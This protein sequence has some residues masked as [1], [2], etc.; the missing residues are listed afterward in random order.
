MICLNEF[1]C[2]EHKPISTYDDVSVVVIDRHG[3]CLGISV[4][5]DDGLVTFYVHDNCMFLKHVGND[6][7]LSTLCID[8]C[9]DSPF[10]L[11]IRNDKIQNKRIEYHRHVSVLEVQKMF[12]NPSR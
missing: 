9:K 10:R 12:D 1:E 5:E 3:K 2:I 8:A 7:V 11:C 4:L 6:K